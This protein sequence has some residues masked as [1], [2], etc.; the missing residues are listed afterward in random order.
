VSSF[1]TCIFFFVIKLYANNKNHSIFIPFSGF[2]WSLI[3]KWEESSQGNE[4]LNG[5]IIRQVFFAGL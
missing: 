5:K 1:C 4:Q 2:D 3:F